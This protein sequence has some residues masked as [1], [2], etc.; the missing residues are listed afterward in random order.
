MGSRSLS[1]HTAYRCLGG[2]LDGLFGRNDAR[3]CHGRFAGPGMPGGGLQHVRLP[4]S[5]LALMQTEPPCLP[6]A[7]GAQTQQQVSRGWPVHPPGYLLFKF[8]W[9][10]VTRVHSGRDFQMQPDCDSGRDFL[11]STGARRSAYWST[12]A[13][14]PNSGHRAWCVLR[15]DLE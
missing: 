2:P 11:N 9:A 5:R 8:K 3:F 4:G 6:P 10:K 13:I 15:P 12:P 1:G 7:F 14:C